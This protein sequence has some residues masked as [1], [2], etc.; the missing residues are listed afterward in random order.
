MAAQ[1]AISTH[2]GVQSASNKLEDQG[3]FGSGSFQAQ[4]LLTLLA[5]SAALYVTREVFSKQ[6]PHPVLDLDG[7]LSS[8][9][10]FHCT[11]PPPTDS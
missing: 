4:T 10:K 3:C 8:A 5:A 9:G 6:S 11:L 2:H 7:R 1:T